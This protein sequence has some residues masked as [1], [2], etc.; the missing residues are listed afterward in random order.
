MIRDHEKGPRAL[1][2]KKT[3]LGDT[4]DQG[5]VSPRTIRHNTITIPVAAFGP[6]G[7]N[8]NQYYIDF[9]DGFLAAEPGYYPCLVAPVVFPKGAASIVQVKIFAYDANPFESADFGIFSLKLKDGTNTLLGGVTTTDSFG[10]QSY[11]FDS[12]PATIG[13]GKSYTIATCVPEDILFYGVKV[14]YT[15]D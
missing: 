2:D 8:E 12:S 13:A 4:W 9:L 10:I 15:T 14:S 7:V 3:V 1:L 6:T 5:P 11:V